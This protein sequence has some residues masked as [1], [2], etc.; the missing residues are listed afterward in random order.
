MVEAGKGLD[1]RK[2]MW[3]LLM[4]AMLF[5]LL[6]PF[7]SYVAALPFIQKSWELNN[8]E[9]GLLFSAYLAGYA[10]SSLLIVPMTDRVGIRPILMGSAVV[11]VA[12]HILFPLVATDIVSGALLRALAG[13]GLSGVYMPGLRIIS[14]RFSGRGRGT[15]M[16]LFVTAF[17]GVHSV[18]LLITGALMSRLDWEEAYLIVA[19]SAIAGLPMAYLVLRDYRPPIN[20]GLSGRLD[21]SVLRNRMVRVLILGYSLHAAEI[22]VLRV[23][24][25]AFL[26]AVLVARGVE[27]SQAA[28]TGAVVGGA[29]LTVGAAGPVMGGL[30][31]D[32]WGRIAS[33]SAIFA[34]SGM[35][36]MA[37]GWLIDLPWA[38]IVAVSVVFGWTSSA[39]SSIYSTAITEAAEPDRLGSAQAMQA[40]LGLMGG[41]IG[42]VLF[43]GILD[44]AS[45]SYRWGIGFSLVGLLSVVAIASLLRAGPPP[46]SRRLAGGGR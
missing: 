14:E 17:Y 19:L 31:Y 10:L 40:F 1:L 13:V 5:V 33:A 29:A 46:R 34:A 12:A 38:L 26:V 9:A 23:W 7:S 30:L 43:G 36:S 16:G 44:L 8:T 45:E 22:Y 2:G 24:L 41:V 28:V 15:A 21:L 27:A 35:C 39:D 32:R 18:S 6:L 20:G 3:L 25:P 37:F 11:S 4:S 42:P